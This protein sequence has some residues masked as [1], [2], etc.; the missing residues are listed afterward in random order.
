MGE[1]SNFGDAVNAS[2]NKEKEF[3]DGWNEVVN[4][5]DTLSDQEKISVFQKMEADLHAI[6]LRVLRDEKEL[7]ESIN[8]VLQAQAAELELGLVK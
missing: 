1:L 8:E 5:L 4:H 7:P 3:Y 2:V 6:Y